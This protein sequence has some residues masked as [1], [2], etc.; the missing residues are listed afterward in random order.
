MRNLTAFILISLALTAWARPNFSLPVPEKF[1]LNNG[2][3]VYYWHDHSLPL[4]GF[5]MLIDGAGLAAE[6]KNLEGTA[7]LMA[8]LMMK[9]AAGKSALEVAEALDFTGAQLRISAAEEYLSVSGEVLAEH[10]PALFQL[11]CDCLLRPAFSDSEFS[12]E[13]DRRID[14]IKAIK[15]EPSSA[16]RYYFRKYYFGQ[17]PFGHLGIGHE[18][19]LQ[20]LRVDDIRTFYQTVV[21]PERVIL[22]VVGDFKTTELRTLLEKQLAGWQAKGR[23]PVHAAIPALPVPQT[24]QC[25]L[26]D[27][28][29]ATQAYFVLGAPGLAMGENTTA[30]AQVMNTLFGGRFTSWLNNELRVKRGLTYGA[31]SGLESWKQGGIFTISSYTKNDKIGEM[32]QTT[33]ALMDQAAVSGFSDEQTTSGR[34]YVLGQFPPKFE[35]LFSKARA[36]TELVYYG[37]PFDYYAGYLDKVG[38]SETAAINQQAA[39]LMSRDRYVL[40]VVGKADE[41]RAQLEP[42]GAWQV[43]SITEVGF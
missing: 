6:P 2:V 39:K 26:I 32:L 16:V 30:T 13:V 18:T 42:F 9:G 43:R 11:S 22:A 17:H 8:E 15:D 34:N 36:F 5:R 12:K 4:V 20:A 33:L 21:R 19:S 40:V 14:Q 29:D 10:W 31:R 38:H 3:T 25:L 1:K 27:K 24:R 23:A 28:P 7:D 41:I 35:T 37:L